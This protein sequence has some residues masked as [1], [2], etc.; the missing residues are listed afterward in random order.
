MF[1]L[2]AWPEQSSGT[3]GGRNSCPIINYNTLQYSKL[4]NTH[5]R[6]EYF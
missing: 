1:C 2:F 5:D 6:V 4:L 3:S